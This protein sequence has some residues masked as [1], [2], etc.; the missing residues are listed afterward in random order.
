ML[1][2]A[3]R[4]RSTGFTFVV[5]AALTLAT[6]LR[7]AEGSNPV[8]SLRER[9]LQMTG[10]F[11]TILPGVLEK[12]NLTLNLRPKFSDLRANE[13]V[14]VP[15]E[16]RYGLTERW[17]LGAGLM[18]FVPNPTNHG[19]DY[20]GGPGEARLA[21]RH[22]VGAWWNFF[23][24][25]TVGF[26]TRVPLGRPPVVL[27]DHYTHV[28][29]LIAAS[30]KL[31]TWPTTRFY[32]NLAYD[33]SVELTHRAEPPSEVMRR[34]IIEIL[35]GFFFKPSQLGY[36][37][38]YRWCRIHEETAW[39]LSHELRTGAVWD[40]PLARTAQWKLPGKWQLELAYKVSLEEGRDHHQGISARINWRTTLR[41][42]LEHGQAGRPR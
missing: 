32:L 27:N 1:H 41:E 30:R 28:K 42:V 20:R 33:R 4:P 23:T 8:E 38:E 7:A 24:E 5:A 14:R 22:D 36:F 21:I 10:F 26:E 40:V 12:N 15:V 19:R 35:P 37:A 39:H 18:P 34:N 3:L 11:D 2:L 17:E 9:V 13:Y 6:A 29:P 31:T 16:L 25:T